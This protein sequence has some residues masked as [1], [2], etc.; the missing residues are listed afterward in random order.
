MPTSTFNNLNKAKQKRIFQA[1][2]DEFARADYEHAKLS[3]IIKQANIPRGSFYQYFEDKYDLYSYLINQIGQDKLSYMSD[4][5]KNPN[6]VTFLQW[7]KEIYKVGIRFA[8]DNPKYVQISAHLLTKK[9]EIYNKVMKGNIDIALDMYQSMIKKDQELGIIK[10]EINARLLAK[11]VLDMTLN[12]STES[13]SS[14][15]GTFNLE[16][17]NKQIDQII[18]IFEKGITKGE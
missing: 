10:K 2:L 1:A 11:L 7:F 4:T 5:L 9:G 8:L 14:T 16:E 18:S 6:N 12:V 3:H 15:D 17:M 13:L